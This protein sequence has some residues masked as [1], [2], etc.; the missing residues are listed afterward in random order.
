MAH[1]ID[2][3]DTLVSEDTSVTE[4]SVIEWPGEDAPDRLEYEDTFDFA[5]G[6]LTA[7]TVIDLSERNEDY[8]VEGSYSV[9]ADPEERSWQ[10]DLE[11]N[12]D[13][14]DGPEV[15]MRSSVEVGTEPGE[16]FFSSH[17]SLTTA[18]GATAENDESTGPGQY[19]ISWVF[20][21][22]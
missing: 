12:T 17:F 11:L 16:R 5:P 19:T 14:E 13:G 1:Q 6:I 18:S 22:S 9:V 2:K 8:P 21:F 10:S 7:R 4:T 15:V 20:D 3:T